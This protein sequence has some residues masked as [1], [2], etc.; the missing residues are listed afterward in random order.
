MKK[1]IITIFALLLTIVS[2][3]QTETFDIAT[4]KKPKGWEKSTKEG[5]ISYTT[6]DETKGTFC[7]ITIYASSTTTG[8]AEQEF[9]QEWN[10]F[11]ATPFGLTDAPETD[12]L[13]DD[14]GRDVIIGSATYESE[15]I[16]GGIIMYTFVGFGR[17][18]SIMF[19]TNSEDHQKDI[20]DFLLSLTLKKTA[21]KVVA[22]TT[23]KTNSGTTTSTTPKTN[24]GT[25]TT[26]TTAA[27][28]P[29]NNLEGPWMKL[30]TTQ[31]YGDLISGGSPEWIVFFKNGRIK[32]AVPDDP[33]TFDYNASDLG[34]YEISGGNAKSK[35]Y[36]NVDWSTIKFKSN[37]QI[38]INSQSYYRCKKVDGLKLDGTWTS[39]A[40]PNDPS[41][42]DGNGAKSMI[43]FSKNG[44]FKDY[45]IFVRILD[46]TVFDRPPTQAG[47]GTYSINNFSLTLNYSNGTVRKIS[48]TGLLGTD[49]FTNNKT[50]Y[51]QRLGFT[52][53]D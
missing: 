16:A 26:A 51:L 19:F 14:D 21:P 33:A 48:L 40:N 39:Y 30:H 8:T 35:W 12:T 50:I 13:T 10:D 22:T 17:T 52:K 47:S 38:E 24:T 11:A 29:S 18:N 5:L 4:Y 15:N 9:N 25:T 23:P 49:L 37:D 41:L 31:Y 34:Y 45:G 53:R 32:N 46:Q 27:F 28:K 42:D 43:Q 3:A 1:N 2:C 20:E 36:S 44:S 7:I 6:S